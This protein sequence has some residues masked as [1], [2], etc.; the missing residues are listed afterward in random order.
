MTAEPAVN[1]GSGQPYERFTPFRF[2]RVVVRG[3]VFVCGA[4]KQAPGTAP[5]GD[6]RQTAVREGEKAKR[7]K[8][9]ERAGNALSEMA[10]RRRGLHHHPGGARRLQA[11]PDG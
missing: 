3:A 1:W 11:P 8:A 10:E 6:H 4:P 9:Q 5:A 2:L 7:G